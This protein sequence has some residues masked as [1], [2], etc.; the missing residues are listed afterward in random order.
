MGQYESNVISHT[1]SFSTRSESWM[2]AGK[3]ASHHCA[4][5]KGSHGVEL[6]GWPRGP[7]VLVSNSLGL[8]TF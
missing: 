8:G 4:T 2:L 1:Y 7:L 5:P 6:N 3:I